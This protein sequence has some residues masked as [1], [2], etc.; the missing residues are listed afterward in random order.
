MGS[1]IYAIAHIGDKKLFVG[2][3]SQLSVTWK[4]MLVQL[5]RGTFPHR[6]LQK[7]W[8]NKAGKRRFTFHLKQDIIGDAAII[9]IEKLQ[10]E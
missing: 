8:S 3:A 1:K 2:D 4:P 7:I 6:E 5:N 10:R 9:G